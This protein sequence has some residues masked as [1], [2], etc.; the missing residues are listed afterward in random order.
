MLN[1]SW[2]K[3][4]NWVS[5]YFYLGIII[6]VLLFTLG[7]F[8][9]HKYFDSTSFVS[10]D[11]PHYLMLTVSLL[12][13]GDFNLKNDYFLKRST[14]YYGNNDLFPHISP[15]MSIEGDKWYSIHTIG[16]PFLL[17]LPYKY[18]GLLGARLAVTIIQLLSIYLFY[19]VLKKYVGAM[20][21]IVVGLLL[22]I[23][24]SVFWQNVGVLFPDLIL[25]TF[26]L[27]SILLFGKK[28][29][30]SNFMICAIAFAG[31]VIHSKIFL[32]VSPILI[33]HYIYLIKEDGIKKVLARYWPALLLTITAF[34]FY[35]RFLLINYG[36]LSPS[37]LYGNNGQLFGANIFTNTLAVLWDRAKGIALYFP[38]ILLA[39]PFIYIGLKSMFS[40]LK[41]IY[42]RRRLK[43]QDYLVLATLLGSFLLLITQLGFLDWSGSYAPNGRYVLVFVFIIIFIIVKYVDF[44]SLLQRFMIAAMI[45]LNLL[46]LRFYY[47]KFLWYMDATI[48][49]NILNQAP[50][51]KLLPKFS[52]ISV[53]TPHKQLLI[54]LTIM[55]LYIVLSIVFAQIIMKR[56]KANK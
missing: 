51:L 2:S 42:R 3:V 25:V 31:L 35:E 26:F 29:L 6:A 28:S 41:K 55:T 21:N 15:T 49:E 9:Y 52:D 7:I 1:K 40:Y 32:L 19:L 24:S 27:A 47:S 50:F 48:E 34:V 38:T 23:S 4:S 53:K 46:S 18:L 43:E 8:R 17:Y 33:G 56:N 16:L 11:E 20:P 30:L 5:K 10:G 45:V 36:S 12:E 13:D 22:L 44:K 54:G 39:G 14:A 37:R